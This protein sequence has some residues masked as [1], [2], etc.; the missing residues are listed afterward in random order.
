[1][2][3]HK[4]L[5]E[6]RSEEVPAFATGAY[7]IPWSGRVTA[8]QHEHMSSGLPAESGHRSVQLAC[9]KRADIVAKVFWGDERKCL[10][11][12]MRFT[13]GDVRDHIVSSKIDHGLRSSAEKRRSGREVQRST[14]ARF[15]G[16]FDF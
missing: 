15:S 3:Q 6:I 11:Q 4:R 7:E 13:S 12:L 2:R 9:L 16:L 1:M 10:E 14:L 5:P 8:D